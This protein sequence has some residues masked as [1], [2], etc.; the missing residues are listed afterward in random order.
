MARLTLVHPSLF[1]RLVHASH[2]LVEHVDHAA[3]THLHPTHIALGWTFAVLAALH[4]H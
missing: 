2:H 3:Y 4:R 1:A